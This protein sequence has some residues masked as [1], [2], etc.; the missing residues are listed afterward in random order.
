MEER[1]LNILIGGEAGQGLQTVGPI[2][3]KGLVR[4][5][6]FVHV[7]QI[8]ESR[9]RGG[10]NTFSIRLSTNEISAPQERVDILICLNEETAS[11]HRGELSGEGWIVGNEEWDVE[12]ERWIGVPFKMFGKELHWNVAAVGVAAALMGLDEKPLGQA[13][14]DAFGSDQ[15]EE[16]L[17]VLEAGYRWIEEKSYNFKKLPNIEDPPRRMVMNGH[18]AVA[19]GA[20]SAG[21]KF[22]AFYPMSP[23][24]SIPQALIDCS[25]EMGLVI[26]Q[27][28]DE[29]AAINM[30]VGASYAG[31]PSMVTTSGGGFALMTETVSLSGVSETPLVIAVGQR[32]GPGTGLATRT[33]QGDLWF[34][35]H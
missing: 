22:C 20:V 16:N 15:S 12:H 21:L 11:L 6:F 28:E 33:E 13:I 4:N 3:T 2:L 8:Y 35:L 32:P 25:E 29:I 1:T 27:A 9:V 5:G 31:V 26:E 10:H 30:A 7:T 18:E 14:E 23:S 19:L 17:R 24:T 34:V